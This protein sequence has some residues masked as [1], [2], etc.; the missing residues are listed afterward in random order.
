MK[1]LLPSIAL[2]GTSFGLILVGC[3]IIEHARIEQL[4]TRNAELHRQLEKCERIP[5]ASTS[6]QPQRRKP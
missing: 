3:L 1:R 4:Q 6:I 5:A 2:C